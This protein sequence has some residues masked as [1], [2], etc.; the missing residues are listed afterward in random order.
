MGDADFSASA[1]LRYRLLN[2]KP[3]TYGYVEQY[4]DETYKIGTNG[5]PTT[6]ETGVLSPHGYFFP[7]EPG[8][9][10]PT[11]NSFS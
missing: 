9:V 8:P 5:V 1:W 11:I 7:T 4:F 6:N 2:G 3:G 10:A